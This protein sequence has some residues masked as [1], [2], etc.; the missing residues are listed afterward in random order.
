MASP[1]LHKE[2]GFAAISYAK[3]LWNEMENV[4]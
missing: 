1:F 4:L 3:P 2:K